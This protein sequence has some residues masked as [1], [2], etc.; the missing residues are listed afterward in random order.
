MFSVRRY[1]AGHT[2]STKQTYSDN[3]MITL[4]ETIRKLT[5]EHIERRKGLV[6][7]QCLTAVGW[8]AGSVPEMQPC[9][10]PANEGG[11]IELPTSDSSNPAVVVGAALAG[12]L[13]I[14]ICRYQGFM[15]LNHWALT[16]YASLSME[17]W[18]QP[19]KIWIRSLANS[20][21]IGPV[22][23]GSHHSMVMRYPGIKVVAPMFPEEYVECFNHFL[24]D[25][26]KSPVY[27]S[28]HR[29]S[30]QKTDEQ[31]IFDDQY[32][33]HLDRGEAVATIIGIS[34][35]RLAGVEAAI[36][37]RCQ[38]LKTNFVNALWLKPFKPTPQMI[39]CLSTSKFG[40]VVD[41][42]FAVG[43]TAAEHVA[44]QLMLATGKPVYV[45]GLEDK[46]AGFASQTDNLTPSADKIMAFVR[47]KNA[48]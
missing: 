8:V 33:E 27:C 48:N 32:T 7:G 23:G 4:A 14:Y 43:A 36:K 34:A 47:E 1:N 41:S 38:Y 5:R 19:C 25:E 10:D 18:N 3:H 24:S 31:Y 46:T 20:G 6:F 9:R 17:M 11:L 40:V 15:A 2:L 22:A 30:F 39:R 35:G 26:N 29:L 45:L 12:R 13:P 42:D 37:L 28:E 44:H 21:S 16:N